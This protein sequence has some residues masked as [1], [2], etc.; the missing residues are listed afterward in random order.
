MWFGLLFFYLDG[1]LGLGQQLALL[2]LTTTQTPT[3]VLGL[4]LGFALVPAL[5]AI[6]ALPLILRTPITRRR[7]RIIQQRLEA[8]LVEDRRTASRSI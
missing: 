7:H 2:F 5:L 1:Y 8:R 4:K 6:A 3:A